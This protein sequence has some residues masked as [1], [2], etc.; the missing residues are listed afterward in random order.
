VT[1]RI[2]RY[3]LLE[4]V[5]IGG[6]AAVYRGRDTVLDREVAVKVLHPHL[7]QRPESR[8]RFSREARAVARLSHPNIVEIFDYG[9]EAAESGWIVT[10]FVRGRTLRA[11]ADEVGIGYPEIG[12]LIGRSLA[13]ALAHA[14]AAGVIHRDLKPENV[15]ISQE[16]GRC[17]VKLADFGIARILT[18]DERMTVTGT[19]VGSPN[20]M[21]P[22][23]ASGYEADARSD[24]FSLGTILYW[25]A[26][27][28]L[29][30]AGPNPAATLRRL[31]DGEYQD[32]RLANA[33]V[34]DE[35]AAI[36]QRTLSMVPS[37][38]Q[39]SAL[40]VRDS[41]DRV[42]REA[43]LSDAER[44]LTAFLGDPA[45]YKRSFPPRIVAAL[46]EQG[47]S[48]LGRGSTARA[49]AL[50][51]RVLEYQPD[52]PRVTEYLKQL[53]RRAKLQRTIGA[54]AVLLGVAG[55]L[56]LGWSQ[57]W[58]WRK[59]APSES[60]AAAPGPVRGATAP[61][62]EPSARP[63]PTSS[64]VPPP[65][66]KPTNPRS[67]DGVSAPG[68]E[69]RVTPARA[70]VAAIPSLPP[71][72]PVTLAV[73][74]RPYAQRALLDGIEVGRETQRVSFA[75]APGRAHLIQLEHPCCR[76]Y[77]RRIDSA[78][79]AR[80]PE[81]RIP[82]EPKPAMLRVEGDPETRVYLGRDLLGTAGDS[83]RTAFTVPVP[84]GENPYEGQVELQLELPGKGR[85]VMTTRIRAGQ[86]VVIAGPW[87]E[88]P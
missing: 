49:L 5:G 73:H 27:G 31:V 20:H 28:R 10:E 74:V 88:T 72:V 79:A 56:W 66:T 84:S 62:S 17:L 40:E 32:P 65:E 48:A 43:G 81:L 69:A 77:A 63:I 34:S 11:F 83:Q 68:R 54:A 76:P 13:D 18:S 33:L 36:I 1:R 24:I 52:H 3:E 67:L 4:Q 70:P 55:L 41:L 53:R 57:A 38:R 19:L 71:Q 6:M 39:T 75:I 30:F 22:E 80:N 58:P 45:E 2:D 78:E 21:A 26:T 29:P 86:D 14:H 35:L 82:L 8:A 12:M 61:V 15:L 85:M 47:E 44:E 64:P 59:V 60:V 16:P 23:I 42:L 50:F 51:D 37:L 87:K 25:L 7:D 46:V 9:G